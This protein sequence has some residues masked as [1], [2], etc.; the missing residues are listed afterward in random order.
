MT[1]THSAETFPAIEIEQEGLAKAELAANDISVLSAVVMRALQA[2]ATTLAGAR[3]VAVVSVSYDMTGE[4]VS[5]GE[6]ALSSEIDR[7]TRSLLFM[8]AYAKQGER[9]IIKATAIFRLS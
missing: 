4:E 2:H 9:V 1:V 7:Q 3:A 6:V 8:H 5:G